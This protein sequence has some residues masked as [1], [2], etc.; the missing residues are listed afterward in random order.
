MYYL[1]IYYETDDILA[2]TYELYVH[3]CPYK[4]KLKKKKKNDRAIQV[5]RSANSAKPQ[6]FN[7]ALQIYLFSTWM[8]GI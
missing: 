6:T 3:I 5:K 8:S 7:V 2:I 4:Y 1:H